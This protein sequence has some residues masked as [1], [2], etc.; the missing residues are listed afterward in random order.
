MIDPATLHQLWTEHVDRL[1]L[2]AR[3]IGEP[4]EDAVQEAFIRLAQQPV[5]PDDPVA[6]LIRVIRNQILAWHREGVRRRK[7]EQAR[8]ADGSWFAVPDTDHESWGAGE[9]PRLLA[10]L[11][12]ESRQVIVMHLWGGLTF[13]Q[14]ATI[15]S[16][17]RSTVHRQYQR[18]L[19]ELRARCELP[20]VEK[21]R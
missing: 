14:I 8:V 2:V 12:V 21:R 6:W 10:Q 19:A 17:S 16:R 13:D 11:Q 20:T 1:L 9:L 15:L 4:A 18:G 3:S 7:R 5:M